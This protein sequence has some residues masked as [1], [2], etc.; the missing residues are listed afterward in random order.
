MA[1]APFDLAGKVG[2]VTGGNSGIGLGMAKGLAQAGAGVCIWGTNPEKNATALQELQQYDANALALICDVS[3]E[4][5]VDAAVA[6][7]LAHFGRIDGCFANAGVGNQNRHPFFAF[8]TT[9]WR[10]VLSVNLDGVFFTFRAVAKHMVER[11][12]GGTLVATS[13]SS[14]IEGAARNQAY[15]SAKGGLISMVL[16]LAVE[17]ARYQITANTIVPGWIETPMTQRAFHDEKFVNAVL[18]RVPERRWG[19][20]EDF[21]GIAVYFMS[22]AARYHTGDTVVIDGGY[23]KF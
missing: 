6:Q 19:I 15:A 1:F 7:T 8:E 22:E 21:A 14:A 16:G 10:R 3:N 20:G 9:E 11:G 4:T 2:L 5:Q 23:S 18:R 12:G 13:S 17:L